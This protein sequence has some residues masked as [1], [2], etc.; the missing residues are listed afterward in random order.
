MNGQS[1]VATHLKKVSNRESKTNKMTSEEMER[2]QG[3]ENKKWY[4]FISVPKK[5]QGGMGSIK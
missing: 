3:T 1:K 2:M 4:A 5:T